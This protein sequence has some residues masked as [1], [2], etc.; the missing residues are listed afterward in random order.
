MKVHVQLET[1]VG[2][3][4][5][6]PLIVDLPELVPDNQPFAVEVDGRSYRARFNRTSGTLLLT[7]SKPP[8]AAVT[9]SQGIDGTTNPVIERPI[10]VRSL[11]ATKF[12]GDS[13]VACLME[14][15][16]PRDSGPASPMALRAVASRWFP[17]AEKKDK[18]AKGLRNPV[19][20]SQIT[21]KVIKVLVDDGSVVD[22]G[23]PL[24]VIE[25]MKMENRIVAP[26]RVKIVSV[27][28]K[29]GTSV[30]SGD[31]LM[32]LETP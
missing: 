2:G 32:R 31:E 15:A 4:A 12:P 1:T 23:A 21:G 18:G 3:A 8:A 14:C 10:A 22:E 13:E 26:T 19:L 17:G 20:R 16:L 25:A 27:K 9:G 24:L 5:I 7:E 11:S 30:A 28:V 29:E 6:N